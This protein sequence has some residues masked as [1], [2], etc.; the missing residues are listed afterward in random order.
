MNTNNLPPIISKNKEDKN[1]WKNEYLKMFNVTKCM[2]CLDNLKPINFFNTK[3]SHSFCGS[4]ILENV[5]HGNN[6]CPLCRDQSNIP[7]D[8]LVIIYQGYNKEVI[9]LFFIIFL[10]VLIIIIPAIIFEIQFGDYENQF[11]YTKYNNS[12]NV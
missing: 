6:T 10:V 12:L 8:N 9:C 4:C 3:C 5:V 11:N 2:I 1:Y 7:T